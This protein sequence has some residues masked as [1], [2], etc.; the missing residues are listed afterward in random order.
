MRRCDLILNIVGTEDNF[1]IIIEGKSSLFYVPSLHLLSVGS[2]IL[3]FLYHHDFFI[4]FD[5]RAY[6]DMSL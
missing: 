4:R 6:D 5:T 2:R 1:H 3:V